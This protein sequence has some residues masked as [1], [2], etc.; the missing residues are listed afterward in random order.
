[1]NVNRGDKVSL[2]TTV[3]F[4]TKQRELTSQTDKLVLLIDLQEQRRS[5][6]N[7]TLKNWKPNELENVLRYGVNL[8]PGGFGILEMRKTERNLILKVEI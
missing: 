1:M 5:K 6:T 7:W 4:K 3:L 8:R 2:H